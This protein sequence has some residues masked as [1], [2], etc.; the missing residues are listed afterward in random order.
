MFYVCG[1]YMKK[2][3]VSTIL[4]IALTFC[5]DA[6]SAQSTKNSMVSQENSKFQAIVPKAAWEKIFFEPI[7]ERVK[8]YK[9]SDLRLK[10]LPANDLEMRLWTGFGKAP[11]EGFILKRNSGEWSAR[12]L[13][14]EYP[15]AGNGKVKAKQVVQKLTD[16][17]AGW[18]A[19]W[20]KL[21]DAGILT[22]P[23]AEGINCSGNA[24]DG[25]GYVVEYNLKNVY[26]TYMF[27][28]PKYAEC[29]EAQ[30][31]IKIVQIIRKEY[32]DG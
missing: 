15:K 8:S 24:F 25:T 2:S 28:N 14:W 22:L 20:K 19:A 30:Q 26:R 31:M 9:L 12:H 3:V 10:G 16:P 5:A 13:G 17:K 11:L 6:A 21:T 4:F 23:D 1:D 18:D 27:D 32:Y 7:N 29:A